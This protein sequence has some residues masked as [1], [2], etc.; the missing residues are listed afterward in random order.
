MCGLFLLYVID[1][2]YF[3]IRYAAPFKQNLKEQKRI[4]ELINALY[5]YIRFAFW[6]IC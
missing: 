4:F 3:Q 2:D 1:G 5:G 6:H